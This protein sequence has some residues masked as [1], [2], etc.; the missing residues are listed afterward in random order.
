MI[1]KKQTHF[2]ILGGQKQTIPSSEGNAFQ[3]LLKSGAV[4]VHHLTSVEAAEW[5]EA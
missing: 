1:G 5:C 3:K 4:R 2:D